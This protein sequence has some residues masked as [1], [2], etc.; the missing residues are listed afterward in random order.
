VT[1][2][3]ILAIEPAAPTDLDIPQPPAWEDAKA[4]EPYSDGRI[5]NSLVVTEEIHFWAGQWL[6]SVY[7]IGRRLIWASRSM[8]RAQFEAWCDCK[9]PF[10]KRATQMYMQAARFLTE[11]P[12]LHK[13]LETAGLKKTLTLS[14]LPEEILARLADDGAVAGLVLDDI[15]AVPYTTLKAQVDKLTRERDELLGAVAEMAEATGQ[16]Q[17][18]HEKEVLQLKAEL[19]DAVRRKTKKDDAH[20]DG[21]VARTMQV[22]ND[23]FVKVEVLLD[24][25][26]AKLKDASPAVQARIL[27]AVEHLEMRARAEAA[28][29]RWAVEEDAQAT[30]SYADIVRQVYSHPIPGGADMALP[31]RRLPP[32]IDPEPE[33][34]KVRRH[35][36]LVENDNQ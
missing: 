14:Q 17:E 27:G 16:E 11:H 4:L 6:R 32:G 26:A 23:A 3:P 20:L 7:E 29:F 22:L 21:Q 19:G 15:Q 1:D 10:G 28:A 9:L 33:S 18:V 36:R 2:E 13:P 8:E 25:M 31:E 35:V 12:R 5:F 24:E 34:K 30:A